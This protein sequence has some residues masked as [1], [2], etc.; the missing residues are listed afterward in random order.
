MAER[1]QSVIKRQRQLARRT[2]RTQ[3]LK[4]KMRTAVKK[5]M[6]A[7]KKDEAEPLY[8]EAVSIID[9]LVSKKALKKNTAARRKS[10]ITRHFNS[11]A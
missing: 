6:N 1:S 9:S 5:V 8:R 7:S 11:L 10:S 2:E 3:R 4:S